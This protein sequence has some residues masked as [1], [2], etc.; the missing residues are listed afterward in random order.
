MICD[1]C[2][3]DEELNQDDICEDCEDEYSQDQFE[4]E[5]PGYIWGDIGSK[6]A[7]SINVKYD[8][9][10][11]VEDEQGAEMIWNVVQEEWWNQATEIAHE[12]G[13]SGVFSNG[14]QGGWL[15]P[16]FQGAKS[17]G[18]KGQGGNLG[19]PRYPSFD[20]REEVD[21]F[22]EFTDEIEQ[23]LENVPDMIK[24]EIEWLKEQEL[25]DA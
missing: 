17:Y 7:M 10:I 22:M 15:T 19:Y 5:H 4:T 21:N 18:W 14:R 13:Y 2:G 1:L 20:S 3:Y 24:D 9:G 12:F 16:Y 25:I 11:D 8:G 6:T 23:L